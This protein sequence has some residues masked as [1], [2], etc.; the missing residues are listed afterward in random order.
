MS[1][2]PVSICQHFGRFEKSIWLLIVALFI[3]IVLTGCEKPAAAGNLLYDLDISFEEIEEITVAGGTVNSW[4]AVVVSDRSP[5]LFLKTYTYFEP[6][7]DDRTHEL[8]SFPHTQHVKIYGKEDKTAE[9]YA[10]A[11]GEIVVRNESCYNVYVSDK[12]IDYGTWADIM[13]QHGRKPVSLP[14]YWPK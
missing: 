14:P 10:L 9:I 2:L 7:A 6:L 8:F 4:D 3:A 13:S 5:F 11:T 1:G 12:P